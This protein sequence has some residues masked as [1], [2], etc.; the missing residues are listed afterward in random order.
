MAALSAGGVA[1]ALD[2]SPLM[3]LARTAL[4]TLA[5]NK[6]LAAFDAAFS[7]VAAL[8]VASSLVLAFAQ[9]HWCGPSVVRVGNGGC[10]GHDEIAA[11]SLECDGETLARS[12]AADRG[13]LRWLSDALLLLQSAPVSRHCLSAPWWRARAL[14]LQQRALRGA[15]ASLRDAIDAQFALA[16]ARFGL[17][18]HV[19]AER[20][21]SITYRVVRDSDPVG[22]VGARAP[23]PASNDD[24]LLFGDALATALAADDDDDDEVKAK[25]NDDDFDQEMNELIEQVEATRVGE[26]NDDV[27]N[28]WRSA[29]AVVNGLAARELSWDARDL[30]ARLYLERAHALAFYQ[31]D[32]RSAIALCMARRAVGLSLHMGGAQGRRTKFQNFDVANL[33]L[34][35]EARDDAV[36][37]AAAAAAAAAVTG[38][39]AAAAPRTVPL[40]DDVRLD[41]INFTS[42][43]ERKPLRPLERAIVVAFGRA[44]TRRG[45][46]NDDGLSA[47]EERAYVDCAMAIPAGATPDWTVH[48]AALLA[49]ASLDTKQYRTAERGALQIQQL[50]D[51]VALTS[52][53]A[54]AAADAAE[55]GRTG[56]LRLRNVFAAGVPPLH[57]LKLA[58]GDAMVRIGAARTAQDIF[59]ALGE[60][61]R[62]LSC[63]RVAGDASRAEQFCLELIA[64]EPSAE[65]WSILGELRGAKNGG[66]ECYERAWS[67]S[68]GRYAPAKRALGRIAVAEQRWRDAILHFSLALAVNRL[69]VGSWFSRGCAH[70]RL[71]QFEAAANAFQEAVRQAP[72]D[73]ESWANLA[74]SLHHAGRPRPA[75]RAMQQAVREKTRSWRMWQNLQMMAMDAREY[76]SAIHASLKMVELDAEGVGPRHEQGAKHVATL[77]ASMLA[78]LVA[79]SLREFKQ[80]EPT[81]RVPLL[82]ALY[83]LLKAATTRIADNDEQ[84]TV[85][86]ELHRELAVHTRAP[87]AVKLAYSS[88]FVDARLRSLR[89]VESSA[90]D[91]A[92][93]AEAFTRVARRALMLFDAY[94]EHAALLAAPDTDAA[95]AAPPVADAELAVTPVDLPPA[96]S[97]SLSV[98]TILRRASEKHSAHPLFETLSQRCKPTQ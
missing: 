70:M 87:R 60:H 79:V 11:A 56:V 47:E 80:A 45:A 44:A 8:L 18:E 84:W 50:V 90:H 31:H 10:D 57:A 22:G 28:R 19:A 48:S 89:S 65:L 62:V 34:F 61:A 81:T 30:A 27:S 5:R 29:D 63:M 9:T 14:W 73:A 69:D 54:D 98:R 77:D 59:E 42:A 33:V 15:A 17:F 93:E 67:M 3:P 24:D 36:P 71:E 86:A 39:A 2:S 6:R 21:I 95:D 51:Q 25:A 40:E 23:A 12:C 85:F 97:A 46:R 4:A 92:T 16:H 66:V 88:R 20:L 83:N 49:R 96:A 32:T 55:A 72:T 37:A 74:A 38:E 26:I 76:Q 53:V 35:A 78:T 41:A 1:L 82:S 64:K 43:V 52:N 91:F 7:P 75:F 58:L 13:A 94:D 68:N